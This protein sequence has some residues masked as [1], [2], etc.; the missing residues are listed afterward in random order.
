MATRSTK[1]QSLDD[2]LVAL[3]NNEQRWEQFQRELLEPLKFPNANETTL[4]HHRCIDK[5]E[6]FP[7]VDRSYA[8]NVNPTSMSTGS[9][10]HLRALANAL[11]MAALYHN[12][13][14]SSNDIRSVYDVY[15][16]NFF[17]QRYKRQTF[18]SMCGPFDVWS[19]DG[20][21]GN[22]GSSACSP[23]RQLWLDGVSFP[24]TH[25]LLHALVVV[26][27]ANEPTSTLRVYRWSLRGAS[28]KVTADN[29]R[30]EW[31][32]RMCPL[33]HHRW[34]LPN[35]IVST[36]NFVLDPNAVF[37]FNWYQFYLTRIENLKETHENYAAALQQ[38]NDLQK[39]KR[40][41]SD[42][43]VER[44]E[45]VKESVRVREVQL[46]RLANNNERDKTR[47]FLAS[48]DKLYSEFTRSLPRG[49]VARKSVA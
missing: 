9:F 14:A 11:H 46:G 40:R 38:Q 15:Y 2:R 41:L 26:P 23:E 32:K 18:Y 34:R 19:T 22:D 6:G 43:F 13:D 33:V 25:D 37:L 30:D 21:D 1:V 27:S 44:S 7:L 20:D 31:M 16:D 10:Y 48:L 42:Q 28:D 24:F 39:K 4:D 36:W 8:D 17:D 47:R 45:R 12:E 3:V 49:L 35:S 5:R 29:N